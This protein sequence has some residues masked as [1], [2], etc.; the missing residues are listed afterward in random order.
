M[1]SFLSLPSPPPQTKTQ[2]PSPRAYL[3]ATK[4]FKMERKRSKEYSLAFRLAKGENKTIKSCFEDLSLLISVRGAGALS[5]F[6]KKIR[7]WNANL[8]HLIVPTYTRT[9][10]TLFIRQRPER[11]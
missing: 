6:G 8:S 2:T 1:L 10:R 5:S 4:E 7:F 3:Q 11:I 9:A